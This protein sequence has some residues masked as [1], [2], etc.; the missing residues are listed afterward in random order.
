MIDVEGL[1]EDHFLP[2]SGSERMKSDSMV[3]TVS[4]EIKE[5]QRHA[6]NGWMSP[7]TYSDSTFLPWVTEKARE[8]CLIAIE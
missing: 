8:I 3:T 4:L 5:M 1:A 6:E 2:G 7:S